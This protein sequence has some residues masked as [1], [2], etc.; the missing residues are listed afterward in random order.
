MKVVETRRPTQGILIYAV[1]NLFNDLKKE[2]G[3]TVVDGKLG[4]KV[5]T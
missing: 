3:I 4:H 5:L 2:D 1:D